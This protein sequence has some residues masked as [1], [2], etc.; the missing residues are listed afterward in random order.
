MGPGGQWRT[1]VAIIMQPRLWATALRQLCVL[2]PPGWWRLRPPLPRP[3]PGYLGFRLL[4][5]YGDMSH[6]PEPADVVAYLQW[7][8]AMRRLRRPRLRDEG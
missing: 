3:D 5:Q 6:S 1:A 2:A 7:C 8:R 4:T